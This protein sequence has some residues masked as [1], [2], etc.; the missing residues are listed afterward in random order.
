MDEAVLH[1]LTGYKAI[2]QSYQ[3]NLTSLFMF[4][5]LCYDNDNQVLAAGEANGPELTH[6]VFIIKGK[7]R[8]PNYRTH[9]MH[10]YT[11]W[12][13]ISLHN[14]N[15]YYSSVCFSNGLQSHQALVR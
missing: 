13:T 10:H 8:L 14:N 7:I 6:A 1:G 2:V 15:Y 11:T 3:L 4:T 12:H 9:Q 5:L